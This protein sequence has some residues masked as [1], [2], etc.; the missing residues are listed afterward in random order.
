[1]RA[2]V[3]IERFRG[4]P[5]RRRL[6]FLALLA[7]LSVLPVLF[8][9]PLF[10]TPFERDQGLYGVIAR[11]WMQGSVPYR[12]LW[13]NTGPLL[14]LWYVAAFKLLGQS[15]VAPRLLAA[16]GTAAAV[17]FVWDTAR[18]LLGP[19]KGILAALLFGIAFG[20]PFLQANANAEILMLWPLAAGFWAFTRGALGGNR[21]WF[22]V[23]GILTA[24]AALT[25]Q[26]A[27]GPL[28]GYLLWL[29]VLAVRNPSE[30]GQQVQ[31]GVLLAGGALLGLAPF[32][33][34]FAAQGALYDFFYATVKFNF[35]FSGQNPLILKI[36]P[37]LFLDPLPLFGGLILWLLAVV[38]GWRLWRRRDRKAWLILVFAV[39]SEL[40]AQSMGKVSAHYNVG[41]LPAVAILGAVGLDVVLDSWRLGR[42]RLGQVAIGCAVVS[43]GLS[44]ALY[45]FPSAKDRFL[46]QYMFRDYAER[47]LEAPAI[48]QKVDA[49]TGPNDYVYEFGR[50]SDI[51]FLADRRPASRWIH[52]RA[53]GIDPTMLDEVI[54]DLDA[55]QPKLVLL[56]YECSPT[57][58]DFAGCEN[59]PPAELKN[60]LD[61]HY[62]YAGQVD[63]ASFYLRISPATSELA[64]AAGGTGGPP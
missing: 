18:M 63:Y 16:L 43:V 7:A 49:L 10:N 56:T 25:K 28:A 30:R 5:F 53:Y 24:L 60:Y 29:G 62:V 35:L 12:D 37:P 2:T 1:L 40:A 27:A 42:R 47:S 59:G 31:S 39:F 6:L 64:S 52:A 21:L 46:A 51:E 54:R 44:A 3:A 23:A 9:A 14:F 20:N 22:V 13:D 50:Q 32:V 38:G 57:S 15:V 4:S 58:H 17:P 45:A 36:V 8:L 41:L 48:A 19:R 55:H 34:Y 61:E 11:G 26:A 33:A